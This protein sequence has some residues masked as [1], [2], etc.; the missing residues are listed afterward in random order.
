MNVY[1]MMMSRVK[2]D[3]QDPVIATPAEKARAEVV[4][5]MMHDMEGQS[6][7]VYR[8]RHPIP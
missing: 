8:K 4:R 6:Y 5:T 3:V 1:R 2:W 7:L